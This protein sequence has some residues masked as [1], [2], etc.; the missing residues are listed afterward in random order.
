LDSVEKAL[1]GISSEIIVVDNQSTDESCK[2]VKQNFPKVKLIENQV[3]YGFS[4]ANNIGV[5]QAKGELI[6]LL[7]PDTIVAEDT[8]LQLLEFA[9]KYPG[10]GVIGPKLIDGSGKFLPESKRGIPF[11]QTAFFKLIGLNRVFPKSTYFNAYYAPFLGEGE[12]G[13][14]PVLVGACML[15]KRKNYIDS[16]GLDEQ[17]F[18]YGE[19][20]DV[21]FRMIKSGYKNY[22]AGKTTVIHFKGESTLKDQKYFKQFS[23]AMQL[24]YRKHF[25]GNFFLNLLYKAGSVAL[26]AIK[27]IKIPIS[28]KNSSDEK[29][30]CLI[31]ESAGKASHIR[32]FYPTRT[33]ETKCTAVFLETVDSSKKMDVNIL[34]V[35][36]TETVTHKI[37]IE[38]MSAL[39][40]SHC[41]FA[42]LSKSS[43]F[44]LKSGVSNQSGEVQILL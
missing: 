42:F 40:D 17:F 15:I 25:G 29:P 43:T 6:C 21:S 13:E 3:N 34:F 2:F 30:I 7:N 10:F 31:T 8:F 11:P 44:M 38:S 28:V 18:M 9:G 14:V 39:K 20:I 22:Y 37:I 36:D 32:A 24:F 41:E 27:L 35:F 23:E 1:T 12:E 19:D 5:S 26:S 33:V 4:K 16:G